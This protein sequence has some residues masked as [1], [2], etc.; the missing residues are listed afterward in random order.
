MP[1]ITDPAVLARLKVQPPAPQVQPQPFPGAVPMQ[2]N[3]ARVQ[4][5]QQA[6]DGLD[7][8]RNQDTRAAE[9]LDLARRRE[10]IAQ[11]EADFKA[12]NRAANQGVDASAQAETAAG[13]AISLMTN[14]KIIQEAVR[15]DPKAEQPGMAEA[16][17]GDKVPSQY[18]GALQSS[19]RQVVEQSYG[20][21][22]EST[23]YL[24][25]GAAAQA[26]QVKRL[27]AGL[28]PTA[29][30]D[31]PAK[32]AKAIRLAAEIQKARSIAGPAN[33]KVQEALSNLEQAFPQMYGVGA[34]GLSAEP[35]APEQG[36][37]LSGTKKVIPYPEGYEAKVIGA[38]NSVPVGKLT[39]DMYLYVRRQAD[40][41]AGF[42]VDPQY[43]YGADR[44]VADFNAGHKLTGLQPMERQLEGMGQ[45]AADAAKSPVGTFL[46]NAGNAGSAGLPALFAGREGRFAKDL[47]DE[48]N[49]KSALAGDILGSLAPT[50]G[51]EGALTRAGMGKVGADVAANAAY[52]G[53]KGFNEAN[54]EDALGAGLEGVAFGGGASLLGRGAI[55]GARGF[56][57]PETDQAIQDLLHSKGFDLPSPREDNLAAL[58]VELQ[59]LDEAGLRKV[60]AKAQQHLTLNESLRAQNAAKE[61]EIEAANRNAKANYALDER[62]AEGSMEALRGKQD[63]AIA[64][65][66]EKNKAAQQGLL[67]ARGFG[68]ASIEA[69]QKLLQIGE[70]NFPT[71]REG[72]LRKHPEL[73]KLA[74]KAEPAEPILAN[75]KLKQSPYEPDDVLQSRI[76]LIEKHLG[77]DNTGGKAEI[78]PVDLTTFQRAGLGHL[79]GLLQDI[80]GVRGVREGTFQQWSKKK[81]AEVLALIGKT[82]PDNVKPGFEMN[83]HVH[84]ALTEGY[85]TLRPHVQGVVSKEFTGKVKALRDL[86]LGETQNLGQGLDDRIAI[87]GNI[88]NALDYLTKGGKFDGEGYRQ[89]NEELRTVMRSLGAK[90]DNETQTVAEQKALRIVEELGREA[91][92]LVAKNNPAA[93]ARLKNLNKAYARQLRLDVASGTG[94][95]VAAE[96][97]PSPKEYISGIRRMSPAERDAGVPRDFSRGK[98][99]DQKPAMDAERTLGDRPNREGSLRGVGLATAAAATGLGGAAAGVTGALTVPALLG[100]AGILSYTPGIKRITQAM[101]DGKIGSTADDIL[102]NIRHDPELK[103]AGAK[104]P[105]A[106]LK[107]L[108]TQYL[109]AKAQEK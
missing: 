100:T 29:S 2:G 86:F 7:I 33:V 103:K 73:E 72:I 80:P 15:K 39:K 64:A 47:A 35:D 82:V 96:G 70:E 74:P 20:P 16:L 28:V 14:L 40:K 102:A 13:H 95:S 101:I 62:N 78:P 49:P 56:L 17:F 12:K 1:E 94:P 24:A 38:I 21:I 66:A 3:P 43:D 18:K 23:I 71:T 4:A 50:A 88:Q 87:W 99:L 25:T 31:A 104:L 61:A 42:N 65:I 37:K 34:G 67:S 85:E 46:M 91:D 27:A 83:D 41:E 90:G 59:G 69:Q 105:S 63:A 30:D 75:P 77:L 10:A 54:P 32:R 52:G 36:Y 48:E 58:P 22:L 93:G 51:V 68:K 89:F 84:K 98:A 109:R 76:A 26:D 44:V 19:Q 9:E 106:A 60:Q 6:Q 5:H 81:A 92:N 97:V 53:V 108:V 8:R 45:M 55:K 79:E 57:A 107:N 11:Q